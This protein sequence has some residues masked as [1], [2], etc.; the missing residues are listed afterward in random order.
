M[1]STSSSGPG[2]AAPHQPLGSPGDPADRGATVPPAN[3][4]AASAVLPGAGTRYPAPPRSRAGGPAA[5]TAPAPVAQHF[6]EPSR[7]GTGVIQACVEIFKHATASDKPEE[8]IKASRHFLILIAG[9]VAAVSVSFAFAVYLLTH[10]LSF[11]HVGRTT[12]TVGGVG[13]TGFAAIVARLMT[14]RGRD[15]KQG[16]RR[17]DQAAEGRRGQEPQ[18][19]PAASGPQER[20]PAARVVASPTGTAAGTPVA[21]T[22]PVTGAASRARR[23]NRGDRGRG[24]RSRGGGGN[25]PEGTTGGR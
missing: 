20:R 11:S 15:R 13:G 10:G 19:A 25:G 24:G 16:G 12:W 14:V 3:G 4:A 18:E 9:V 8:Q 21:G 7:L 22:S 6:P 17:N 23:R 5:A 1:S 2:S